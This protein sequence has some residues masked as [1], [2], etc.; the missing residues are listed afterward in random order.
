MEKQKKLATLAL[1]GLLLAS[2]LPMEG[3]AANEVSG[4][5]LAVG[6]AAHGCGGTTKKTTGS[7]EVADSS[8]EN[9]YPADSGVSSNG[10]TNGSKIKNPTLDSS[11]KAR[12]NNTPNNTPIS[13]PSYS[14]NTPRGNNNQYN[15]VSE[16]EPMTSPNASTST[17]KPAMTKMQLISQLSPQGKTI[18][19]SLDADGQDLAL[20]LASQDAY[21]DKDLAVK[22][23]QRTM[24]EQ[25]S[26]KK[27]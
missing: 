20:R 9:M 6:C 4:T 27:Y 13:N 5:L 11:D 14:R 24:N 17:T 3:Q 21:K 12:M 2:C 25:R 7:K 19:A 1:A 10:Q 18:F 26:M 16:N 23:A 8:D 22:E 15:Y